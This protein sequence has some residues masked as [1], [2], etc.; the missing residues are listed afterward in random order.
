MG[1]TI[2]DTSTVES[3]RI[4]STIAPSFFY[5]RVETTTGKELFIACDDMVLTIQSFYMFWF[6]SHVGGPVY[7]ENYLEQKHLIEELFE[8]NKHHVGRN[9]SILEDPLNK[10]F[11]KFEKI[12]KGYDQEGR[13]NFITSLVE[14]LEDDPR[15]N[16]LRKIV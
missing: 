16:A 4:A 10:L 7:R 11:E 9:T 5:D 6:W 1:T 8:L 2:L 13:K 12:Y 14:E 15:L 3:L